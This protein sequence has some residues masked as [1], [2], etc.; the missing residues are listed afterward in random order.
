[1]IRMHFR[2]DDWRRRRWGLRMLLSKRGR[3]E[4]GE[5]KR[6]EEGSNTAHERTSF[7]RWSFTGNGRALGTKQYIS[8]IR[9]RPR[10]S[11]GGL[12]ARRPARLSSKSGIVG[13]FPPAGGCLTRL[14]CLISAA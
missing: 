7:H 8:L 10:G 5:D 2:R 14:I 13:D 6:G 4:R 9:Y 3:R 1:M 11:F 12:P